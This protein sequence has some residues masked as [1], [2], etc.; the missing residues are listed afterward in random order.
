MFVYE[1][2]GSGFE[3]KKIGFSGEV[4]KPVIKMPGLPNFGHMTI[5]TV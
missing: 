5:S 2:S 4:I 1:L 3:S